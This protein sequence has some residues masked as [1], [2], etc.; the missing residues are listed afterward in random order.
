MKCFLYHNNMKNL[1]FN[2]AKELRK[3]ILANNKTKDFVFFAG[4]NNILISVPHGVSQTRLG[5]QK[6][7]EIGTIPLGIALA[8]ET[9]SNLLVKTKNNFDDANFD[10]NCNYRKFICKLAESGKIKYII[11]LHGLAS[12]R[13]YD[14]NLGINFGNNIKQ[15]TILFDKITKRLKQHFNLSVDVPFKASTKTISGYFAENFDIWTIQIETN[16]SITNSSK[17]IDK[18][19]LLLKTL[20]DWLKEIR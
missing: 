6:V 10:E 2:K 1:S 19:N 15:N 12:W 3:D 20:A 16:C 9:G 13:N 7:A 8:K 18:F 4:E 17:N 11:D 14:I 5:K